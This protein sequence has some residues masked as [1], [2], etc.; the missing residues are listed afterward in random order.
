MPTAVDVE[1]NSNKMVLHC[2]VTEYKYLLGMVKMASERK[3]T[4]G[5][6]FVHGLSTEIMPLTL[7]GMFFLNR[8]SAGVTQH[9]VGF[10]DIP[11]AGQNAQ[12]WID[13][14]PKE[15]LGLVRDMFDMTGF[16]QWNMI[17]HLGLNLEEVGKIRY[18]GFSRGFEVSLDSQFNGYAHVNVEANEVM[19]NGKNSENLLAYRF[20][21][22]TDIF[23]SIG[24]DG[25]DGR[26]IKEDIYGKTPQPNERGFVL[27]DDCLGTLL[28]NAWHI[29]GPQAYAEGLNM[30]RSRGYK[31]NEIPAG[32]VHLDDFI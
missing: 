22:L 6:E 21:D 31:I 24:N 4:E 23:E 26:K 12:V 5:L 3:S 9:G 2:G 16:P 19:N 28:S 17:K 10:Y 25:K 7:D 20:E 32:K 11:T 15:Q 1:S 30:L 8:R 13:K 14:I 18:T 29:S 27:V